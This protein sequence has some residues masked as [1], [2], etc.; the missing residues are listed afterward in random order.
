MDREDRLR[1]NTT[2]TA[3]RGAEASSPPRR[4]PA[5]GCRDSP[6]S[7]LVSRSPQEER[8]PVFRTCVFYYTALLID[9]KQSFTAFTAFTKIEIAPQPL[10]ISR[11][12]KNWSRQETPLHRR[13]HSA[14]FALQPF[15]RECELIFAKLEKTGFLSK[16]SP[17]S[18]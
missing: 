1:E 10:E 16:V 17:I 15:S 2:W 5:H 3:R 11:R 7:A 12:N 14:S 8:R 13:G 18:S 9:V 4:P 6:Q